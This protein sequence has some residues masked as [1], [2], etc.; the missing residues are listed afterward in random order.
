MASQLII[1]GF[2]PEGPIAGFVL[3]PQFI[4]RQRETRFKQEWRISRAMYQQIMGQWTGP[5]H[6][7][8]SVSVTAFVNAAQQG[9]GGV[10]GSVVI[11][12]HTLRHE[13]TGNAVQPTMNWRSDG[14]FAS[15]G[16]PV[17]SGEWHDGEPLTTGADWEVR[18]VNPSFGDTYF[19][20]AA[21]INIW[22]TIDVER[23]WA[24]NI[25]AKAAP[26]F[27]THTSDFELGVDGA[28]SADDS[29]TIILEAQN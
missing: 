18:Q 2:D 16:V 29:A 15:R 24:L 27:K 25:T 22:I 12:N 6:Q 1:T 10:S 3:P 11:T 21:S 7:R 17:Q 14:T 8:G 5:K 19:Q 13:S 20:P 9:A 23:T 28:E 26:D 4:K